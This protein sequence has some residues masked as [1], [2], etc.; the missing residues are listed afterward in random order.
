MVFA[1]P[2]QPRDW[3]LQLVD[4][5]T[6]TGH[7]TGHVTRVDPENKFSQTSPTTH[8]DLFSAQTPVVE[9]RVNV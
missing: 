2:L 7:F 6:L 3:A 1:Q 4:G 9:L 5:N 8:K